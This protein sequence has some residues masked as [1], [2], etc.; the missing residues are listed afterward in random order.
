MREPWGTAPMI[1]IPGAA[2]MGSVAMIVGSTR[3]VCCNH[4][5]HGRPMIAIP[6]ADNCG[7]LHLRGFAAV[8]DRRRA[9]VADPSALLLRLPQS[10]ERARHHDL[11]DGGGCRLVSAASI[12]SRVNQQIPVYEF[13]IPAERGVALAK[14]A[15]ALRGMPPNPDK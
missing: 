8:Q 5:G 13:P 2:F 9:D 14:L 6:P 4:F 1:A 12:R 15:E 11:R 7:S 10:P 3:Q